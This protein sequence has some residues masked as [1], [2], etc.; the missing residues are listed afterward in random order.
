M[1]KYKRKGIFDSL[2]KYD[3]TEKESAYIEV[4]QWHNA[5]GF[6]VE[7]IGSINDRFQ[8]TYSQF[9]ALKKLVKKLNNYENTI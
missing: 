4:T 1:E 7:L 8:M 3:P 6:D 5:E 9:D 2:K